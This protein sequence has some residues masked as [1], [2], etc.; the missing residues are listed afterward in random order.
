[1][2]QILALA[3]EQAD[4]IRGSAT[5]ELAEQRAEAERARA[6]AAEA[7]LARLQAELARLRGEQH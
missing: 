1:V 5:H 7:E 4:A 2:E 6:A 3:E